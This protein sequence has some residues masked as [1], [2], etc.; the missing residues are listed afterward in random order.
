MPVLLVYFAFLFSIQDRLQACVSQDSPCVTVQSRSSKVCLFNRTHFGS[1]RSNVLWCLKQKSWPTWRSLGWSWLYRFVQCFSSPDWRCWTCK[2]DPERGSR[3]QKCWVDSLHRLF[4]ARFPGPDVLSFS[5][6][7]F[8]LLDIFQWIM[9]SF[10][11]FHDYF[12]L[13]YEAQIYSLSSNHA[14]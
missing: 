13:Q 10:C 14:Y 12:P 5:A 2:S 7:C 6:A 8:R 11:F 9:V 3:W 4:L 1:K